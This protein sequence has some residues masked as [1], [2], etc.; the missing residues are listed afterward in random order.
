MGGSEPTQAPGRSLRQAAYLTAAMGIVHVM[1][2]LEAAEIMAE[3]ALA[4]GCCAHNGPCP[5]GSGANCK[6]CQL[7][8]RRPV[9]GR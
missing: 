3:V 2:L 6:H 5:C 1:L 4:D 8:V 9:R 7:L